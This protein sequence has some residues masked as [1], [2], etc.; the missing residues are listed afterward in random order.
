M[1]VGAGLESFFALRLLLL[2]LVLLLDAMHM[3]EKSTRT[4]HKQD[5]QEMLYKRHGLGRLY[6]FLTSHLCQHFGA[7]MDM[8]DDD[9]GGDDV[10]SG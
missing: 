8:D 9:D 5:S 10:V 3:G 4:S 7:P 6:F 2:L 1:L